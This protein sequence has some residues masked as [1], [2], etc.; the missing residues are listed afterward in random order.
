MGNM[1]NWSGDSAIFRLDL[2]FSFS[3]WLGLCRSSYS[4]GPSVFRLLKFVEIMG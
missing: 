2:G 1:I 3:V 4:A